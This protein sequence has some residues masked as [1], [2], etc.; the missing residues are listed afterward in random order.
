MYLSNET[1]LFKTKSQDPEE[2]IYHND[3]CI[4]TIQI[5]LLKRIKFVIHTNKIHLFRY[6][7]IINES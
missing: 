3:D 1:L 2:L 4:N 6:Q 7:F 5:S